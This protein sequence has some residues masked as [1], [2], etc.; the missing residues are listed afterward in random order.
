V[1]LI[2]LE[3]EEGY[4]ICIRLFYYS[5]SLGGVFVY[6]LLPVHI[7][8]RT[9]GPQ[10]NTNAIHNKCKQC[11]GAE[12]WKRGTQDPANTT[13]CNREGD[14]PEEHSIAGTISWTK[15]HF[16]SR[17]KLVSQRSA[18]QEPPAIPFKTKDLSRHL[19][20]SF[21]K[22]LQTVGTIQAKWCTLTVSW[23]K[24]ANS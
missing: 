13:Q 1:L 18:V 4:H 14:Q 21:T 6:S 10:M 23:I 22:N 12:S 11:R 5:I 7:Y 9:F 8:I 19:T 15:W 2:N 20:P 24:R 16:E 3:F 17:N